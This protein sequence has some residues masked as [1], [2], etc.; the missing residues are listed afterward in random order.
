MISKIFKVFTF[1]VSG[2]ARFFV[3][4]E[5]QVGWQDIKN[6]KTIKLYSDIFNNFSGKKTLT[7]LHTLYKIWTK[8]LFSE[9]SVNKKKMKKDSNIPAG[10]FYPID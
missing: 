7:V 6:K 2:V 8:S 10:N 3:K 9:I 1:V 5:P 4:T